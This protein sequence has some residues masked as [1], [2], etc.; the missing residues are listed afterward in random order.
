MLDL[1]FGSSSMILSENRF[2]LFG[3]MLALLMIG[4]A[5]EFFRVM[6]QIVSIVSSPLTFGFESTPVLSPD[7]QSSY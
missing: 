1:L 5:G 4:I 7:I 3:I 2:P 6:S